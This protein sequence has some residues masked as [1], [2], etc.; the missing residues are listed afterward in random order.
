MVCSHPPGYPPGLIILLFSTISATAS[1]AWI[2]AVVIAILFILIVIIV[3]VWLCT[4][5]RGE[6]YKLAKKEWM[7]L[8]IKIIKWLDLM[9][10]HLLYQV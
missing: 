1:Y 5:D 6:T 2:A 9:K 10:Y 8:N 7:V 3:G 4:R